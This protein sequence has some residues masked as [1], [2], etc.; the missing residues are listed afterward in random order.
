[1][2]LT[3][4]IENFTN[5][6]DG[7]PLTYTVTG[8]RG[9]DIGRDQHLDFVLPDPKRYI[10]G[11]HC[12]VRYSDGAYLLFDSSTNG[13]FVNSSEQRMQSPHRLRTGDRLLIGDY[14]IAVAVE[15]DAPAE[16]L[17][18]KPPS[19]Q[20]TSPAPDDLWITDANVA[21]PIDAK[22]LRSSEPARRDDYLDRPFDLLPPLPRASGPFAAAP[23]Q[24]STPTTANPPEATS[25]PA[26][27]EEIDWILPKPARAPE[28]IASKPGVSTTSAKAADD[29]PKKVSDHQ[30]A[31]TVSEPISESE[32]F[33][34]FSARLGLPDNFF[35][36]T[37][38]GAKIDEIADMLR[39]VVQEVMQLLSARGEAK[40]LTRN[41]HQTLMQPV[42][43]NPLRFSPT[44]E[45][46]LR[47]MLGQKNKS[48]L[49]GQAALKQAFTALKSHQINSYSAMQAAVRMIAEDLD[50]K[51]IDQSVAAES[52]I[53]ALV[54]S[55]RARLWDAYMARWQ[56]LTKRHDNGLVDVFMI[57]FA[58]YY[59]RTG[60]SEE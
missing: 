49:D 48:Y 22:E 30:P 31:P 57:Y 46:C 24:W 29:R 42:D 35:A 28:P 9:I 4:T 41:P 36:G 34:R 43:N 50:P 10:S 53:S 55:R 32:F 47:L 6:P 21:P 26:R 13:T 33:R 23:P 3:L 7:G 20:P 14:I 59:N 44:P 40:R 38:P 58:D 8:K 45:E 56:A 25:E 54:A 2:R 52:G 1:M 17:P 18:S 37:D 15:E 12:E 51:A 39:I 16:P 60:G 19:N 5:L 27:A 11:K